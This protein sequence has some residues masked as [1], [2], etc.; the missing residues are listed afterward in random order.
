[1]IA[2][3]PQVNELHKSPAEVTEQKRKP[4]MANLHEV[5]F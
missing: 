4:T 1:M 2:S 5:T 3:A